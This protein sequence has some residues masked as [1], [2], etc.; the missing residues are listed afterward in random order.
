MKPEDH[1]KKIER[2]EGTLQKLA[3]EEDHETIVELYVLMASHYV[4]AALH[5]AGRLRPDRD[6]KHNLLYGSI[7]RERY[8]G[9]ESIRIAGLIDALER[10]RPG[11]AYG[12]GRNGEAARRAR[13]LYEE[14]EEF[15]RGV[16]NAG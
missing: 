9:E 13:E 12:R 6:L 15:C 10:L 14:L 11:Q 1:I 5:A 7:V 2:F 16:V 8:F 4:N 3:D